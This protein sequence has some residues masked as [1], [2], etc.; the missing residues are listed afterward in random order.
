MVCSGRELFPVVRIYSFH[1]YFSMGENEEVEYFFL[2]L[3]L[4]SSHVI[5]FGEELTL[6]K[7][8]G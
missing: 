6:L 2:P 7:V 8:F 1:R 3:C 5:G 4:R